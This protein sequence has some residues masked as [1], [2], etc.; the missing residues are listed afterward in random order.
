[1]TSTAAM[2][3]AFETAA[4]DNKLDRITWLDGVHCM[5]ARMLD[6]YTEGQDP[7]I[8]YLNYQLYRNY[9]EVDTFTIS[10]KASYVI[11]SLNILHAN[12]DRLIRSNTVHFMYG[13][14]RSNDRCLGVTADVVEAF[15]KTNP[16]PASW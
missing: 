12:L 15:L 1:M 6:G 9:E 11:R 16:E 14:Y 8:T 2:T 13:A 5:S 10:V 7:A 3:E 4:I